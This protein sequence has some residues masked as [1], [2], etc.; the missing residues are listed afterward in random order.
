[1]RFFIVKDS[2]GRTVKTYGVNQDITE[3]KRAEEELHHV[4][5]SARCILWHSVVIPRADGGMHWEVRISNEEAAEA[6]LP[7][8]RKPGQSY[9]DV[10]H[11]GTLPEDRE[12][13]DRTSEQ[14][15]RE[16]KAGYAQEYRCRT[17]N[18]EIRWLA[19]DARIQP[20]GTDRWLVIGVCTDITGRREAEEKMEQ[21]L[22][23]L[24]RWHEVTV[25]REERVA[26]LKREVN[27]LAVR[28]GGKPKYG[29][30]EK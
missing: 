26:E 29:T 21:Q 23:E 19:E 17:T 12:R 20:L 18:G 24:R 2:Q 4:L 8:S 6:M 27:E 22:E 11:T 16:G 14:A 7:L 25:G 30:G 5:S 9:S 1:V 10:W 3:R 13:I 28:V 15:I